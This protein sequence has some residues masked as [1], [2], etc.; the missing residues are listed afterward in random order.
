[1]EADADHRWSRSRAARQAVFIPAANGFCSRSSYQRLLLEPDHFGSRHPKRRPAR[2]VAVE[3]FTAWGQATMCAYSALVVDDEDA[4]RFCIAQAL[5][6]EGFACATAADGASALEMVGATRYDIV[7][8]DLR[9]PNKHG[10]ALALEILSRPSPPVIVVLTGVAEPRLVRDLY[11]RGVD[12]VEFKPI[13][14][15][16][17]AAKV[18][19]LLERKREQPPAETP[20]EPPV[21]AVGPDEVGAAVREE[22]AGESPREAAASAALGRIGEDEVAAKLAQVSSE[23]PISP[24]AIALLLTMPAPLPPREL[25]LV[26]SR[27]PELANEVLRVASGSLHNTP[28]RPIDQLDQ[29]IGRLGP[30]R[31][32]ELAVANEIR[33]CIVGGEPT[34]NPD[35]LWWRSLA[36]ALA[37]EQLLDREDDANLF[38]CALLHSLG[39][40]ILARQFA[41]QYAAM[42]ENCQ[43][44]GGTLSS[45]EAAVFPRHH[46][47]VLAR[48]LSEWKVPDDLV[49]PLAFVSEPYARIAEFEPKLRRQTEGLKIAIGLGQIAVGQWEPWDTI[50]FPPPTVVGALTAKIPAALNRV[51]LELAAAR[52]LAG[53]E[54]PPVEREPGRVIGYAAH[55]AAGFDFV[56][57]ALESFGFELTQLRQADCDV[58]V[59]NCLDASP[60]VLDELSH[61][62]MR[63][64]LVLTRHQAF[65]TAGFPHR[66]LALPCSF[67]TLRRGLSPDSQGAPEPQAAL[68]AG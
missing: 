46:T 55:S 14:P 54:T 2:A 13:S 4:W 39:R 49:R 68:V 23:P 22:P 41:P 44:L 57:A 6:K 52:A 66:L 53:D 45:H 65:D 59:V 26:I 5:T 12:A 29:A 50:D 15:K 7:I 47:A 25:D 24:V 1:V 43:R 64:A 27:D 10:H 8:T 34:L 19:I 3:E 17:L 31:I 30:K 60:E 21:A 61:W 32:R 18:R 63:D 51:K 36:A 37:S 58:N 62:R 48:L 56:A 40:L 16:M 33:Q 35:L 9:M 20:T 11:V 38:V 67:Q 42:I 28:G